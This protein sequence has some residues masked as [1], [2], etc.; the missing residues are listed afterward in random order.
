MKEIQ[1][2]IHIGNTIINKKKKI[3]NEFDRSKP[4]QK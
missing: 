1:N 2:L 4:D 3:K